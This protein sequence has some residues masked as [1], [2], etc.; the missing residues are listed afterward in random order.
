M[1][2]QLLL[3]SLTALAVV[4]LAPLPAAGQAADNWTPARTQDGHPDLQGYWTT[5]T[6]TP[7]ERPEY[8]GDK[9]FYTEEEWSE[10]QAQLTADGVDPLAR[11]SIGLEDAEA[12]ET[13]LHQTNRDAEYVHYDNAI[14][15]ATDV[16]KGLSTRRTSLVTEPADGQVPPLTPQARERAA[17][18]R[19]TRQQRGTFDGYETRPFSER[20][21]AYGHN[22]PPML[23]PAYNDIHQIIQSRDH[24]VV[25]TEMSN[26]APRIIPLDGRPYIS[27][28]VRQFPGDSR[29]HWEGDTLVVE[30]KNFNDKRRFQ[31]SSAELQVVERFTRVAE[32][33]I[34]YEFTVHDPT[35]WAVPWS[36]EVPLLKT[37]GPM[38]EYACHEGNKDLRHLLE[39]YRNLERQTASSQQ[40]SR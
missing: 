2:R 15:L 11:S 14:W 33:R 29:G 16:K 3:A 30:S 13:A 26:N 17:A 31:G 8:L 32:D 40:G 6:F 23:P 36:V 39:I 4:F 12:R 28:K 9:R 35:T 22:G 18:A 24:V 1:S 37:E 20:C 27:D 19:A 21:I 10:L 7:L 38:F 5:Q 34:R 25:F